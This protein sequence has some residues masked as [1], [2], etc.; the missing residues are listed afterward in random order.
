MVHGLGG[1]A[2]NWMAVGPEIANRYHAIAVD[3]AGFGQTPLFTRSANVG[4][5]ADLVHEFIEKVIGEPVVIMGN[6]MGGHIAIL[7][8]AVHPSSVHARIL[9]APAIPGAHVPRPEPASLAVLAP[10]TL[11]PPPILPPARHT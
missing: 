8:A 5:N 9:V 7:E 6:S 4:G 10:L 1:S 11:P 2:L 3:L